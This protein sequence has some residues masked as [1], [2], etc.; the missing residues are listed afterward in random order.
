MNGRK[1]LSGKSGWSLNDCLLLHNSSLSL[2]NVSCSMSVEL[3]P[4]V[5]AI[6]DHCAKSEKG[7][8]GVSSC[9]Y[10]RNTDRSNEEQHS[11]NCTEDELD[12]N[13]RNSE[14]AFDNVKH[15]QDKQNSCKP[16][17]NHRHRIEESSALEAR[18]F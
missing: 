11:P 6:C 2:S 8:N 9:V 5:V 7:G 13:P 15:V 10:C 4:G 18:V 1:N 16:K 17:T 14:E 3:E 12:L